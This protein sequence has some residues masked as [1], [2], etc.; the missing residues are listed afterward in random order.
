MTAR[1]SWS[2]ARKDVDIRA[3]TDG[4]KVCVQSGTTTSSTSPIIFRTN[5]MKYQEMR[6]D[7]RRTCAKP[8]T[9][10]QCNVLTS[11][12]SQLYAQRLKLP[13]PATMSSCPT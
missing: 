10:G 8:M 11:D 1:A 7:K 5:N 2:A 4:S 3:R 12:V 9:S 6:F 13:S